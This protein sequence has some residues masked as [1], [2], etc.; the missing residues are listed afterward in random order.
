M[1][2]NK[3][4]FWDVCNETPELIFLGVVIICVAIVSAIYIIH[5]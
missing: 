1:K 5:N 4:N 2:E 3:T